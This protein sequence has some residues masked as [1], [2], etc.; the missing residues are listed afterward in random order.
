MKVVH[1]ITGLSVGGAETM[2]LKLLSHTD[3]ST[4]DPV[5]V[6][7][8][9]GGAVQPRIEALGIPVINIGMRQGLPTPT[10]VSK[11]VQIVGD[12]NADILQGWMYHGNLAAQLV[13]HLL[14]PVPLT[15]WNV[16]HSLNQAKARKLMTVSLIRL[17]ALL[18]KFPTRIIYNSQSSRDLHEAIGYRKEK[19]VVIPNGFACAEFTPEVASRQSVREELG[20]PLDA[21]LIGSIGR[22]HPIKGHRHFLEGA[23]V[24]L[25]RLNGNSSPHF[26][27]AGRNVDE[28]NTEL[29][30]M[31]REFGIE[32]NMHLLSERND[33]PR[34]MAS[35][36]IFTSSSLSEA[37]PNVVGEA[38]ACQV[39]CVVT[40]VGDSRLIIGDTG[41][42]VP[43]SSGYEL[44]AAWASLIGMDESA[45]Q[46][47]GRRA[48][49]RVID[50][51]SLESITK[52]YEE[53][54]IELASTYVRN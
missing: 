20:I 47:L 54:Y 28:E 45:R 12:L 5:V 26:L 37:F 31:I 51:F 48:R 42:A 36:D 29:M 53:L 44:A 14:R 40:D 46:A 8:L 15:V 7:L 2:L 24:L 21:F 23:S 43:P 27:M 13:S 32:Q 1:I 18:S 9:D 11:L 39:P 41:H 30:T 25:K 17:G 22:Y 52:R 10:D 34:L 38:M 19:S 16:R 50:H 49:Q 33:I 35:L 3:L 6:S 4:F